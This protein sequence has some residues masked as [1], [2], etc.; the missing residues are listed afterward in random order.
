MRTLGTALSGLMAIDVAA[1]ASRYKRNAVLWIVIALLLATAYVFALVAI[2]LLLADR[3][4]PLAAATIMAAVLFVTALI[5][6]GVMATFS[7]RDRR[8]AED[9]RRRAALQTNLGL[10]A[11]GSLL[12]TQPLIALGAA[13]AISALLGLG[14]GRRKSEE[15][16]R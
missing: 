1:A 8:R 3:Y 13:V 12:R 11:A 15:R 14:R 7:A 4:S 2:A 9:R 6:I 10:V 5:L 16:R